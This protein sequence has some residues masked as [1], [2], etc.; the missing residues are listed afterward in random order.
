MKLLRVVSGGFLVLAIGAVTGH[1]G[2]KKDDAL[3]VVPVSKP[4]QRSVTDF[5]DY[6]GRAGAKEFVTIQPRVTGYLAKIAFKE[7]AEVKAGDVL[8]E[9][10]P[11]PYQAQAAAAK[12]KVAQAEAT[13]KYAKAT[14]ARFKDI[15]KKQAG[16]V[17]EQQLDQYQA[18]EEQAVAGLEFDKANLQTAM[19]NLD[20]TLVRAPIDGQVG[21]WNLTVGNLVKQ[22]E[23]K[24]TTL[25]S[26]DS[27]QVYFE[28]D[29]RTLLRIHRAK[30]GKLPA[31]AGAALTI[32]M[33]LASEEGYAH[34]GT[35]DFVDNR[36]NPKTGSVQM[37]AVF[38]K[39]KAKDSVPLVMPG[40]AVR[41]RLTIDQPYEALLVIDRA[42]VSDQG[43]KFV[44]VVDAENKVE[45][46][47]VTLGQLQPDGL[48]VVQQGLKKDDTVVISGFQRLRARMK[49]KPEPVA[50]PQLLPFSVDR[51]PDR[52]PP[53]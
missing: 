23:T 5:A 46:R 27:M 37:R 2:G 31:K 48:R 38:A 13:L 35:V 20:W 1:G 32:L 21:R 9:I 3:L 50:M 17:S 47:R 4:V 30:E 49:I 15:A 10:D 41:L 39:P 14:Y 18:Q 6:S 36:V 45:L 33:G 19:L 8:F 26:T 43:V 29:E 51:Q 11:R 40:M 34:Q 16:T 28:V 44:W 12:A 7:G 22:D 42:V 53:R 25:V 24:L 52:I